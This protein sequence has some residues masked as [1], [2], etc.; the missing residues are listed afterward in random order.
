MAP[1]G[2]DPPFVDRFLAAA[3]A[4]ARARPGVDLGTAREVMSEAATLL[5]DGLA[6]D[7]LDEHDA[8]VV[9][10]G[11]CTALVAE[12]PGAAVRA[13]SRAAAADPDLHDPDAVSAAYLVA[14]SILQ[15]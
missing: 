15:L 1:R 11:L 6:L 2:T 12:D 7:G 5:H 9:V 4:V 10:A 3:D 14:S 13:R 8:D